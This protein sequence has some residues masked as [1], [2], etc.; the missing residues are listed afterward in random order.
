MTVSATVVSAAWPARAA[1]RA[2]QNPLACASSPGNAFSSTSL[3]KPWRNVMPNIP[4][5]AAS[6]DSV[7]PVLSCTFRPV[8]AVATL[9]LDAGF[10]RCPLL[11]LTFR[12][13]RLSLC[14][15]RASPIQ[16]RFLPVLYKHCIESYFL[17]AVPA[18]VAIPVSSFAGVTVPESCLAPR[19]SV[20]CVLCAAQAFGRGAE[21]GSHTVHSRLEASVGASGHDARVIGHKSTTLRAEHVTVA[22]I[23]INSRRHRALAQSSP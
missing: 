1:A 17:E 9:L 18:H 12:L 2:D 3:F 15:R 4:S 5:D 7:G 21:W 22:H 6:Q 19:T 20:Q 23:F 11:R 16:C 13:C 8:A 14:L 10:R